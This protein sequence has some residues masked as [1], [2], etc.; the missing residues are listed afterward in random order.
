MAKKKVYLSVVI[1]CYNEQK[2]LERGV[3]DEVDMYMSKQKYTWEVIISD[4]ASTDDSLQLVERYVKKHKGFRLLKNAHGGKAVAL[5]Y[6][7]NKAKGEYALLTD[8]D[9]STPVDQLSRLLPKIDEGYEVIIGSR[10]LVRKNSSALRKLA[11][12]TFSWV[13]RSILLRHIEDTQCGFKLVQTDLGNKLFDQMQI[14]NQA[15]NVKGWVVAAWD[16]E[17][18]YVA[19]KWGYRVAEVPVEWQDEDI[20]DSKNR[21]A[22]KFVQESIDMLKQIMRV[23]KND[24]SGLYE[25]KK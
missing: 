17:F 5:R 7:L 24:W 8:M 22:S 1:P 16:V 21:S 9:Q 15:A 13:R 19:E 4:D 2:N 23:R 20:S 25:N 11:S 14:F 12:A 18:L 3:L 10:G 6:G